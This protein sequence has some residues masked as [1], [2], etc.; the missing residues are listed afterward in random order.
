MEDSTLTCCHYPDPVTTGFSSL[1]PL[2]C[3]SSMGR[4]DDCVNL[5][6]RRPAVRGRRLQEPLAQ[7]RF[8]TTTLAQRKPQTPAISPS[9]LP[10]EEETRPGPF[11]HA[12]PPAFGVACGAENN[13]LLPSAVAGG[14]THRRHHSPN[15][16][17]R[18]PG[19]ATSG[20]QSRKVLL[21]SCLSPQ[22]TYLT[23]FP[24]PSPF[25]PKYPKSNSDFPVPAAT[26][27][28]GWCLPG[29]ATPILPVTP[30]AGD[31]AQRSDSLGGL[32]P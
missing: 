28:P 5:V 32:V 3:S 2:R 27:G 13:N 31:E 18:L 19:D 23:G 10:L 8:V 6:P 25:S 24:T 17:H 7:M 22:I 11:N 12:A 4:R 15:T 9:P 14:I 21:A 1:P 16:S 20:C 26:G 30:S 29:T